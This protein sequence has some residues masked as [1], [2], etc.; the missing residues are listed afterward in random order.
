MSINFSL[1]DTLLEF[2]PMEFLEVLSPQWKKLTGLCSMVMGGSCSIPF[3]SS[4]WLQCFTF[5]G[6]KEVEDHLVQ[7][8]QEPDRFFAKK[9]WYQ[10]L[11]YFSEAYKKT[12]KDRLICNHWQIFYK[13]FL[14]FLLFLVRLEQNLLGL[15]IYRRVCIAGFSAQ[16]K[17][18]QVLN[19]S[20]LC[21]TLFVK[22]NAPLLL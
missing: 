2:R 15:S 3:V 1:A 8:L 12:Y 5:S 19:A 16:G 14:V 20:L 11:H 21:L 6:L 13:V 18:W 10:G 22:G 17:F 9:I 7:V 4:H